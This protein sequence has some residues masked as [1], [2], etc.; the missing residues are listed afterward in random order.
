MKKTKRPINDYKSS[1]CAGHRRAGH[2]RKHEFRRPRHGPLGAVTK[3]SILKNR[4]DEQ[5]QRLFLPKKPE[6][7]AMSSLFVEGDS[8]SDSNILR[9]PESIRK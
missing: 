2:A 4:D 1:T 7:R 9:L 3:I 8:D 5:Q 6:K